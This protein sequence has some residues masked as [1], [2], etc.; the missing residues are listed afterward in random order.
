MVRLARIHQ[1]RKSFDSAAL[2]RT[3][4]NRPRRRRT[5]EKDDELA[6]LHLIPHGR[7]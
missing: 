7:E 5:A 6:P 4:R 3:R 1:Y 2:L